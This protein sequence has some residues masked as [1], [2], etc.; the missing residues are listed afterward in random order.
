MSTTIV[1]SVLNQYLFFFQGGLKAVVWTDAIQS[2]FTTISVIIVIIL[3]YIQA[4]GIGNII[5]AN[6]EGNR[7]EFF[8]YCIRR[9]IKYP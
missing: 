6:Q 5:K 1:D 3:G 7:I 4:G 9:F 2:V 8:R